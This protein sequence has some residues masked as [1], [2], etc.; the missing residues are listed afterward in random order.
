MHRIFATALLP[1]LA[2]AFFGCDRNE[3]YPGTTGRNGDDAKTVEMTD[4]H[5]FKPMDVTIKAGES[6]LWKNASKDVH[7]V[8]TEARAPARKDWVLLPEGAKAFHS[9]D[10]RP[11]ETWRHTFTV[12]GTYK[13]VCT[14]HE[15]HGMMGTIT[16]K[17]R[18]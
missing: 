12:A 3:G 4:S 1:L 6:I 2:A 11:G 18:N 7:T 16:V 17:A 15:E 14:H 10:L 5:T 13:Y 8:S 9:G